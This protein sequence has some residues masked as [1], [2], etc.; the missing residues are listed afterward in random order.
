L[1]PRCLPCIIL[2]FRCFYFVGYIDKEINGI[3]EMIFNSFLLI[4]DKLPLEVE[5]IRSICLVLK[6]IANNENNLPIIHSMISSST[7]LSVL[8]IYSNINNMNDVANSNNGSNGG[9]GKML[10]QSLN[11][12]GLSIITEII[13]IFLTKGQANN[14]FHQ[15]SLDCLFACV[16]LF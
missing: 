12:D 16:T 13:G 8:S 3:I 2:S 15:V 11:Y 14:L 7:F 10:G 4:V 5:V 9:G 1:F 6:S